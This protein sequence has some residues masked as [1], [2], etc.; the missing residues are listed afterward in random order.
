MA[1]LGF[2]EVEVAVEGFDYILEGLVGQIAAFVGN[3]T[4]LDSNFF[5][6]YAFLFLYGLQVTKELL[7]INLSL[8]PQILVC[9]LNQVLVRVEVNGAAKLVEKLDE[10][11]HGVCHQMLLYVGKVTVEGRQNIR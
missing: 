4:I 11:L 8:F 1:K 10:L 2:Y 7:Q 5:D 3:Q 9:Q 6:H